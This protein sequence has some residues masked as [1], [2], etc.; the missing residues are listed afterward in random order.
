MKRLDSD[1]AKT[2]LNGELNILKNFPKANILRPSIVY[3]VDDN[4]T[5]NFMTL[6]NSL[7][8]FH[9]TILVKPSLCLFTVLILTDIIFHIISKNI[10]TN[11]IECVGPETITF[12]EILEKLLKLIKKKDY[13]PISLPLLLAKLSAYILGKLPKPLLTPDQLKLLKYD[14]ISSKKYKTNFDIGVPSSFI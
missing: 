13:Y 7:P 1:Y 11:I 4:F 6:L 14:N 5:T 2:K 9:F 3:S 10:N 8:F 12:K